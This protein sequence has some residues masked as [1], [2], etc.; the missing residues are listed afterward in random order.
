MPVDLRERAERALTLARDGS[1]GKPAKR[2]RSL[3]AFT[4][5]ALEHEVSLLEARLRRQGL[6]EEQDG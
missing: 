6:M 4:R 2:F 5:S 1:D 3:S